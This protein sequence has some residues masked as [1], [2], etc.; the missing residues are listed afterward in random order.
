MKRHLMLGLWLNVGLLLPMAIR[1][2]GHAGWAEAECGPPTLDVVLLG[3]SVWQLWAK[4][5]EKIVAVFLI[6]IALAFTVRSV[7]DTAT[8]TALVGHVGVEAV[9]VLAVG[10]YLRLRTRQRA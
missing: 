9:H 4:Q 1:L 10:N 3:A 6:Q 5:P 8:H 2:I 7:P